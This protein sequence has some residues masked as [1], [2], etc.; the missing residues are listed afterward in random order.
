ME[1]LMSR[2][3]LLSATLAS[4]L[5]IAGTAGAVLG[6][7]CVISSRSAQGNAGAIHSDRWAT[8]TTYDIFGFIHGVVGGT[9]L[10][11]A[12]KQWAVQAAT[13]AGVP[14]SFAVRIDKTIGAGSSNPN[15]VDGKG[16]DHLSMLYGE[17][18]VGIYFEALGH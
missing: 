9:A 4:T 11:E 5:L 7:E 13:A 16:L 3:A 18:I 14:S 8:E 1:E 17:T 15:L 10:T 12:Q 2:R 6:H